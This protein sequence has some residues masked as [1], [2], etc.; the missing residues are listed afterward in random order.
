MLTFRQFVEKARSIVSRQTFA[1]GNP[2]R[3]DEHKLYQNFPG[4]KTSYRI[5]PCNTSTMTQRHAHIFAKPEGQGRQL[6]AVN[7]DGSGHDG[8]SGIE[9]SGSHAEF[10]RGEGF[11]VPMTNILEQLDPVKLNEGRYS[12]ILLAED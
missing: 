11:A 7:V 6:Y 12:L 2:Q 10:L 1:K 9:I 4:E 5:D 3:L 8:S